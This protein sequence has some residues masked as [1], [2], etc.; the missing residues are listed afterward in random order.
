MTIQQRY[1]LLASL[2][3]I[4]LMYFHIPTYPQLLASPFHRTPAPKRPKPDRECQCLSSQPCGQ[5][6]S[7]WHPFTLPRK[8]RR[9]LIHSNRLRRVQLSIER[10][11]HSRPHRNARDPHQPERGPRAAHPEPR[12]H[13]QSRNREGAVRAAHE[14]LG[15]G[16][17]ERSKQD[18]ELADA[19]PAHA[20]GDIVA[21][22]HLRHGLEGEGGG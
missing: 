11:V 9:I 8:R 13:R 7:K 1:C 21:H 16:L 5:P 12:K 18:G 15:A 22:R 20:A 10:V 3:R 14:A 4:E 2:S 17:D 19:Q 6:L